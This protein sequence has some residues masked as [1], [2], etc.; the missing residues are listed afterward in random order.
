MSPLSLSHQATPSDAGFTMEELDRILS[1]AITQ[2]QAEFICMDKLDNYD[3]PLLLSIV[4]TA[5]PRLPPLDRKACGIILNENNTLRPILEKAFTTQSFKDLVEHPSI[6]ARSLTDDKKQGAGQLPSSDSNENLTNSFRIKYLGS[7]A[8][9]FRATTNYHTR[10]SNNSAA[11]KLYNRSIPVIQSSGTGKSRMADEIGEHVLAIPAN[12][13][14]TLPEGFKAYPPP[15]DNLC[16]YFRNHKDPRMSDNLIQA[17]HAVLLIGVFDETKARVK[18]ISEGRGLKGAALA[19]AWAGYLRDGQTDQVV[20]PNRRAFYEKAVSRAKDSI[21]KY[22]DDPHWFP[23]EDDL[24]SI[25]SNLHKSTQEMLDCVAPEHSGTDNACYFYFDESHVLTELPE[26]V[27]DVRTRSS[28]RN[29]GKVLSK[30]RDLPIFFVFLSTNSHLQKFAPVARDYTSLRACDGNFLVP[31]F[32][33]LPFDIFLPDMYNALKLAKKTRSLATAC[34]TEV[35]SDMGRALWHTHYRR[36]EENLRK[37]KDREAV[38]PIIAFAIQKLTLQDT[39]KYIPDSEIAALSI[40]IGITFDSTSPASREVE[41]RQV[42]AHMRIVYAIPEHREYMR[43]GCSSEPIL[44]EAAARFLR[45]TRG[46]AGIAFSG[47]QILAHNIER[48]FLAKGERGELCGR[49]LATIAHDLAID[50]Y[51]PTGI[52]AQPVPKDPQPEFHRPVPVLDFLRALFAENYKN[53]ILDATPVT[54]KDGGPTLETTFKEAFVCFSHFALA[55]DSETLESRCLQTALFRGM[56]M[57]AKD[58]QYS[59]DAVIPIHMGP[60]TGPIT[61]ETTSAINL[62]FKNRVVSRPCTIDRTVTVPDLKQSAISIVFELGQKSPKTSLVETY[63]AQPP[64]LTDAGPNPDPDRNHYCFIAHGC[65]SKTYKAIP[66][67]VENC[68]KTILAASSLMDDFPRANIPE[69]RALFEASK[70]YFSHKSVMAEWERGQEN[71]SSLSTPSLEEAT[72]SG[73]ALNA[74]NNQARLSRSHAVRE[75]LSEKAKSSQSSKVPLKRWQSARLQAKPA[76]EKEP[77]EKVVDERYAKKGRVS[78]VENSRQNR[79]SIG[80]SSLKKPRR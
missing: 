44:A 65:T 61:T 34:T 24:K 69:S 54:A 26:T 51:P 47:P 28:Y 18:I 22:S 17:E 5:H 39:E 71:T 35:M 25:F 75:G 57:Q 16:N 77:E 6:H 11:F 27:N 40:R 52:I 9:C 46:K 38:D 7:A 50:K 4:F 56:A 41:S 43:T 1:N 60:I 3:Q 2:R 63:H 64:P 21:S 23:T 49:L 73:S 29:L 70:P 53:I 12:L 79:G 14:G 59:I 32:T 37:A 8:E 55:K 19:S 15:D 30:L 10:E 67:E 68:Y 31:P 42:E 36:W 45:R 48:G 76:V 58:N 74:P 33:E 13:R 20:G 80:P 66:K 72:A 62:Q 78:G